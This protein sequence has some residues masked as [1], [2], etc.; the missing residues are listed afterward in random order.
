[1]P[2]QFIQQ[3]EQMEQQLMRQIEQGGEQDIIQ[4]PQESNLGTLIQQAEQIMPQV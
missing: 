3:V 2:P 1:M 4:A